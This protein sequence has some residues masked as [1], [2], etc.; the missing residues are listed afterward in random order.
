MNQSRPTTTKERY[1][2]PTRQLGN[3]WI[4]GGAGSSR[5]ATWTFRAGSERIVSGLQR[6]DP[7]RPRRAEHYPAKRGQVIVIDG[8]VTRRSRPM[9]TMPTSRQNISHCACLNETYGSVYL[10]LR[11]DRMLRDAAS[12]PDHPWACSWIIQITQGQGQGQILFFSF[13]HYTRD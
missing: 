2:S 11:N 13:Q 9:A 5:K 3:N 4:C 8:D 12:E 6:S 7:L 10:H 1:N